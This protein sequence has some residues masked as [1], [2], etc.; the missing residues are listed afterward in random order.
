MVVSDLSPGMLLELDKTHRYFFQDSRYANIP[1][2][3]IAPDIIAKI[4]TGLDLSEEQSLIMYLGETSDH[5]NNSKNKSSKRI[6][7][8]RAV[9]VD[10]TVALIA[11]HQF[12]HISPISS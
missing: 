5:I 7:K 4:A 3:R 10:G 8:L 6:N 1:R 12:R 11:G 2:L 9:V